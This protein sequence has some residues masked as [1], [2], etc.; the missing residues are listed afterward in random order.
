MYIIYDHNEEILDKCNSI[1][2]LVV[3]LGLF[4]ISKKLRWEKDKL[5]Y[6]KTEV[7]NMIDVIYHTPKDRLVDEINSHL[8]F[9]YIKEGKVN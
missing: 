7:S 2:V 6:D 5:A 4:I 1:D 8:A 9:G 3:K